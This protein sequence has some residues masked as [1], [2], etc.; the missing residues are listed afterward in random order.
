MFPAVPG[1]FLDFKLAGDPGDPANLQAF[2][3]IAGG[4]HIASV[5]NGDLRIHEETDGGYT[6]WWASVDLPMNVVTGQF[7]LYDF[8]NLAI[9]QQEGH[10]GDVDSNWC[11]YIDHGLTFVEYPAVQPI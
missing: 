1:L 8:V 4:Y 11:Y 9:V 5:A 7:M 2:V 6:Y 3:P 10:E